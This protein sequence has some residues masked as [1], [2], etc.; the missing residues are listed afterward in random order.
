MT[1][2]YL[3]E[4]YSISRQ[5][6]E[7]YKTDE[8]NFVPY[9][10]KGNSAEEEINDETEENKPGFKLNQGEILE[11]YYY[12]S[13]EQMDWSMDY[14]G[15][16]NTGK[17]TLP[18]NKTALNQC[19]KGVK[20]CL[21]KDWEKY[22]EKINKKEMHK[23]LLGFITGESFSEGITHL[24][25]SGMSKLLEANYKFSFTQ[26]L[27]SKILEEVIKTAG[28]KAVVDVRGLDDHV[29][30]YSNTSN[31]EESSEYDGEISSNVS[32]MAKKII[33]GKSGAESKAKAIVDWVW[34]KITYSGYPGTHKGAEGTLKSM[35]GNCCDQAHLCI[36]MWRAVD[37]TARY[38]HNSGCGGVGHVWGQV[39]IKGN[40]IDADCSSSG[41]G[42]WNSIWKGCKAT[43]TYEELPF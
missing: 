15:M 22:G 20:I 36:A 29:I 27:R 26:M 1:E 14:E 5:L 42:G 12:E 39:K 38:A 25:I 24:D 8:E 33:K 13:L 19:Y 11:T 37:L 4:T 21:K 3:P 16:S 7:V 10:P 2:I 28:L 31:I 9:E 17:I 6:L 43:R 32:D 40:Y 41:Q 30:D 23:V 35:S 34:K 18:T